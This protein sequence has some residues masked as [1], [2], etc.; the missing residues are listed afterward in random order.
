M[1]WSQ[2]P[3]SSN[4]ENEDPEISHQNPISGAI[5]WQVIAS[6]NSLQA[7]G[8]E[9]RAQTPIKK[10]NERTVRMPS[11]HNSYV[12]PVGG[13]Q[14]KNRNGRPGWTRTSN[15]LLKRKKTVAGIVWRFQRYL[16]ELPDMPRKKHGARVGAQKHQ[17]CTALSATGCRSRA[18]SDAAGG[19]R[20]DAGG[21]TKL[22]QGRHHAQRGHEMSNTEN[23]CYRQYR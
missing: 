8:S 12:V 1:S 21:K 14:G 3:A 2:P 6:T 22:G 11:P 23:V 19:H 20:D 9:H 13:R 5:A 4:S 7:T 18:R 17:G 10:T 16:G 15:P